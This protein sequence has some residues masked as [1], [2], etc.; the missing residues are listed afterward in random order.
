MQLPSES[1]RPLHPRRAL[2]VERQ[3][4]LVP[5]LKHIAEGAGLAEV[6]AYRTASPRTLHRVRPDVVLIGIDGP[7][8]R[9][10]E[11][12]RRTRREMP[13]ARIVV[14]TRSDDPAWSALAQALG[15][16]VV[17]GPRADR[18]DLCT[19]LTV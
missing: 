9:P 4:L 17:L 13:T 3:R 14:I 18:H 8:A 5:F 2:I 16:D 6:V 1:A 10:L 11:L 12:I 7:G 15:A 19:A